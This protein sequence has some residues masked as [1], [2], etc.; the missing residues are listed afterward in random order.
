MT[1]VYQQPGLSRRE[2]LKRGAIGAALI[3]AGGPSLALIGH[4]AWER[5]A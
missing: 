4:G 1:T 3:I 2:L 5:Q